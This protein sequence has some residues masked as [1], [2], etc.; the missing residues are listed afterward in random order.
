M[1][2]TFPKIQKIHVINLERQPLRLNEIQRELTYVRDCNG[3]SLWSMYEKYTAV[4]ARD[5]GDKFLKDN[6]VDG[7]YNLA[8][9]LFVEP[10]PLALPNQFDLESPIQMSL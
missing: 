8:E 10:Q 2:N 3:E 7:N 6:L 4:D 5:L 9:Q 1:K